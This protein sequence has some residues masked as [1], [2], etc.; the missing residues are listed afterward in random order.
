MEIKQEKKISIM[1]NTY[2]RVNELKEC[3]NSIFMQTYQNF[4]III[5]DDSSTDETES[6]CR[7][8]EDKRVKYFRN[9]QNKGQAFGKK[10]YFSEVTGEYLIFCDDDDYYLL[11]S[12]FAK[13][14]E[15]FEEDERINFVCANSLIKYENEE[16]CVYDRLNF[17]NMI[18]AHEYLSNFQVGYTKP[19]STFS[20]VFKKDI[21][22]KNG[23]LDMFMINDSSIFL[24][25]LISGGKIYVIEEI[26]GIYRIHD[27]NVTK[28]LKVT[29]IIDNLEEKKEISEYIRKYIKKINPEDWLE[30]QVSFTIYYY[31]TNSSY[32]EEDV[33][34]LK[35]WCVNNTGNKKYK[36]LFKIYKLLLK[37]KIMEKKK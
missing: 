3:L 4:E 9:E 24:R 16:R 34:D 17:K 2:N 32:S 28:N 21:L 37:K 14:V 31:L 27:T 12:F 6:F 29:F 30:K 8:I 1:I 23:I 15:A 13:A 35:D 33:E 18:S 7:A 11:D 22:E 10:K 5:I 36:I 20:T 25:S 19:N 26:V